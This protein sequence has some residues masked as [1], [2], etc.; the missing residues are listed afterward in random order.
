MKRGHLLRTYA[1]FSEKLIFLTPWYAHV[2]VRIRGLQMLVFRK[3]LGTYLMDDPKD[4]MK[5]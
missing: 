4:E 2:R 5:L 3:I 1:K